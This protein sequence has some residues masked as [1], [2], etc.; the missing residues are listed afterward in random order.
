MAAR[1]GLGAIGKNTN[2]LHPEAGSWFLLGELFLTLDLAPDDALAD[3]CGSCTRCLEA[4]PTGARQ[5]GNLLDPDSSI[6]QILQEKRVYLFK[7]E[8]GTV[9]RFYYW[10]LRFICRSI[11]LWLRRS[12]LGDL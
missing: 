4:C 9:P 2:L 12:P 6:R 5:F 3:L 1:A 7:E 11:C 10:F 8:A